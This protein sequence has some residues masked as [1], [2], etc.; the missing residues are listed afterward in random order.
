MRKEGVVWWKTRSL[1]MMSMWVKTSLLQMVLPSG[2]TTYTTDSLRRLACLLGDG[3]VSSCSWVENV[4]G[5]VDLA[6]EVVELYLHVGLDYGRQ[7]GDG[8]DVG[9]A[10]LCL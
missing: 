7:V 4:R 3:P 6:V 1:E 2:T 10:C 5:E 8:D 9:R